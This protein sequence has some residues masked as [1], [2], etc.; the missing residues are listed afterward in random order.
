M[1]MA[2]C[3]RTGGRCKDERLAVV[4]AS[5]FDLRTLAN[6][7]MRSVGTDDVASVDDL[8]TIGAVDLD[9]GAP[10]R[11]APVRRGCV[12]TVHSAAS[13]HPSAI[14]LANRESSAMVAVEFCTLG[15]AQPHTRRCC[16]TPLTAVCAGQ[17]NFMRMC[18][19]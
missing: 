1:C 18:E 14:W 19:G 7:G 16:T 10:C 11:K 17:R 4:P 6:Y 9:E 2:I 8:M 5:E 15:R 3:L 12:S 13:G